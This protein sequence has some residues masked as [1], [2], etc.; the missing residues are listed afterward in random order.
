MGPRQ[1]RVIRKGG[2]AH[3]G[4]HTAAGMLFSHSIPSAGSGLRKEE[5]G[6]L[7]C[8]LLQAA[9]Q[10]YSCTDPDRTLSAA[11]IILA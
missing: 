6:W 1:G 9:F 11:L 2:D 5:M 7:K 3:Q 10:K 4:R 8:P